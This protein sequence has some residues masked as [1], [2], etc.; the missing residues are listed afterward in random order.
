MLAAEFIVKWRAADPV[1]T[2]TGPGLS[3]D[4]EL[5][6]QDERRC[7]IRRRR[8]AAV[9]EVNYRV[10]RRSGTSPAPAMSDTAA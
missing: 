2:P 6:E 10:T 7:A 3:L 4:P 5:T 1:L 8:Q 9:E